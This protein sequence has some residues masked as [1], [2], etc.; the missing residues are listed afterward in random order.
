VATFIRPHKTLR[1]NDYMLY[2]GPFEVIT[3]SAV[4]LTQ[5]AKL[6]DKIDVHLP[7]AASFD[8]CLQKQTCVGSRRIT[9]YDRALSTIQRMQQQSDR[10]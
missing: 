9:A 3:E 7:M 1:Q 6:S 5:F 8:R 10:R 2:R 4:S